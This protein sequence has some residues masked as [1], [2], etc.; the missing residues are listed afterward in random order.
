MDNWPHPETY[1]NNPWSAVL[2]ERAGARR[3]CGYI[4][5]QLE[6]R[7]T[8][9]LQEDK[10]LLEINLKGME[11]TLGKCQEYWLLAITAAWKAKVIRK[12]Q[13]IALDSQQHRKQTGTIL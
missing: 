4:E 7:A 13:C 6:L 1:G 8:D 10:Y 5:H 12:Q 2:L 11:T 3:R 9:L